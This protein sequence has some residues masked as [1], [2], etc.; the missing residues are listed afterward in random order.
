ME[1]VTRELKVRTASINLP[2]PAEVNPRGVKRKRTAAPEETCPYCHHIYTVRDGLSTKVDIDGNRS[3][4]CFLTAAKV[5][6]Q[7]PCSGVYA[8]YTHAKLLLCPALFCPALPCPL[9]TQQWSS[10]LQTG[11]AVSKQKSV[12]T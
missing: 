1:V 9:H 11:G 12:S 3:L 4:V 10:R 7:T 5:P 2:R 8:A 6:D